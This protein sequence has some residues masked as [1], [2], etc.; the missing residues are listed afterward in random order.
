MVCHLSTIITRLPT[1][2]IIIDVRRPYTDET[3]VTQ[4]GAF[5]APFAMCISKFRAN[6]SAGRQGRSCRA[7]AQ[8]WRAAGA[9]DNRLIEPAE[10]GFGDYPGRVLGFR[11]RARPR[12]PAACVSLLRPGLADGAVTAQT[13]DWA[14]APMAT[15][16]SGVCPTRRR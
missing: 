3:Q 6:I 8:V 15:R 7:P 13:T 1:Y 2:R 11:N 14:P 9:M 10:R 16:R 5:L 12:A 4:S